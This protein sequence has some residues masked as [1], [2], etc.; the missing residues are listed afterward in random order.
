MAILSTRG[1]DMGN[2]ILSTAGVVNAVASTTKAHTGA[3][4]LL[5][6]AVNVTGYAR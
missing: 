3:Y 4:S 5:F 6:N 2:S 1:F